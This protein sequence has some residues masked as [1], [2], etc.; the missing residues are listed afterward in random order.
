METLEKNLTAVFQ[1]LGLQK[2]EDDELIRT[3]N[4][5]LANYTI[6]YQ[7]MRNFHW[8][9]KGHNFFDLHE[10]FQALYTKAFYNIDKI[11][12][13]VRVFGN[14]PIGNLK[15]ILIL[16]DVKEAKSNLNSSE[17]VKDTLLEF[18]LLQKSFAEVVNI[19]SD[20]GDVGTVELMNKM[21]VKLEKE[22]W[23]LSSWTRD[24]L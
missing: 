22:H 23:M 3:L 6:H 13:R 11:A 5:S 2:P 9:I 16:S 19:A 24:E 21:I 4:V 20:R 7:N 14:T 8:N 12:E 18:E 1:K 10:R 17:M 15:E